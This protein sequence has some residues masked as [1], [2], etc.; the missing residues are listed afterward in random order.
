VRKSNATAIEINKK[1]RVQNHKVARQSDKE[2]ARR[3]TGVLAAALLVV[4]QASGRSCIEV[5][6]KWRAYII[7]D[8]DVYRLV[9]VEM[10][11]FHRCWLLL[12]S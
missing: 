12:V 10:Y 1:R 5:Q 6:Q 8:S 11:G 9:L 7:V 3:Q 4:C 2:V